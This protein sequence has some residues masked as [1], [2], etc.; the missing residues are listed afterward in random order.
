[1]GEEEGE[2]RWAYHH[3]RSMMCVAL[4]C[5]GEE[6]RSRLALGSQRFSRQRD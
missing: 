3:G 6:V 1:M 5:T 4:R 2:L